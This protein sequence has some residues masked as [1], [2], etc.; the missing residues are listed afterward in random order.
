MYYSELPLIQLPETRTPYNTSL[1]RTPLQGPE[2]KT[3]PFLY[4]Y[5][6]ANT[7]ALKDKIHGLKLSRLE[8]VHY[9]QGEIDKDDIHV[10]TTNLHSIRGWCCCV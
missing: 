2:K 8:G 3:T 5:Y 10:W 6:L 1:L 7:K 9:S 4:I